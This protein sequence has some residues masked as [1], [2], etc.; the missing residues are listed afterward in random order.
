ML[1]E[2]S[3]ALI[4]EVKLAAKLLKTK[5]RICLLTGA[6]ISAESGIP[7][8]RD[9]QTGLWENYTAEELATPEAFARDPKLSWSWY[10]WRRQ[11]VADKK[12]NPA[13]HALAQWQ[14]HTQ[15][16]AQQLTLITQ[17]VDDL[18]EQA[19]S[20]V[21]HLH[22]N[23]WRNRCSQCGVP[24]QHHARDLYDNDNT[25]RFDDALITCS[26]CDGHIRPDIV[27]FGEALPIEEWQIAEDAANNCEVFISIGTSSIVYPAAGLA[28]LAKKNGAHVI[29]INPNPTQN[30]I[31]DI[32][33][34]EK[35]G[36]ILP[37]LVQEMTQL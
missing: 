27:W 15:T 29:E 14:Y 35:A 21:T 13:H 12:P 37:L 32:T 31:V 30:T 19:G 33:L 20:T 23:L 9:K 5:Q 28:Q 1:A 7:T 24:Y 3:P 11:S 18:H 8:F 6:G 16:S 2:L 17:N 25:V 22:G 26:H 10:Q 36:I 4:A 34:A